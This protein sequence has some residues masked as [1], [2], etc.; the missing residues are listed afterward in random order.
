MAIIPK[1]I[2]RLKA[3]PIK[4]P[5]AFL[6]LF[7]I[8]SFHFRRHDK[9]I[10]KFIQ[11]FK[12]TRITKQI[13]KEK[14]KVGGQRRP[15]FQ[16]QRAVSVTKKCGT[17]IGDTDQRN[18]IKSPKMDFTFM[19]SRFLQEC[20]HYPKGTGQS[21]PQTMLGPQDIHTQKNETGLLPLTTYK[22]NLNGS[23]I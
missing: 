18:E 10:L 23:K 6:V 21:F 1:L 4:I 19:V 16:T 15:D 11:K 20:R 9:L 17:D 14:T 8:V 13:L 3:I 22:I 12:Q 7:C 5:A 2:C